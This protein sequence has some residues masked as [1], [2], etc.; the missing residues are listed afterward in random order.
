MKQIVII[1]DETD[2]R[3][4]LRTLIT[5]LCPEVEIVGEADGVESGFVL[6]RQRKPQG[7]LLDI[8]MEDGSGFDLLDKF[9]NPDFQV[10]F[11]TAHDDFALRAFRYHALDYL[12]KPIIPAELAQA[13]DRLE[14]DVPADYPARILHLLE[15]NK[16]QKIDNI[17]LSTHEGIVFLN[18]KQIVR[19]ESDGSYTTFFLQNKERHLVAR[20]MREFE[21]LLP[22]ECFFKLHQS[23]IVNLSFV[24]K[25]LKE[26][27]GYANMVDGSMVPIARRR[28]DDFIIAM[29][30]W[31]P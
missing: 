31:T 11:T 28:K 18:L 8:S 30:N 29:K 14:P 20:P 22:A 3:Q 27:G 25:L 12:L 19:L 13:I 23:H 24:K 7:V 21:E 6:I 1:D 15:S 5:Q 16:A 10:I 17:T 4:A 9:P 2:A 26:D